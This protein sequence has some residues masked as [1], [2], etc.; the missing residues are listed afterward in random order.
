[1]E[2]VKSFALGQRGADDL[3]M[4]AANLAVQHGLLPSGVIKLWVRGAWSEVM[5]IHTEISPEAEEWDAPPKARRLAEKAFYALQ[6]GDYAKAEQL[7]KEALQLAPDDP[8]LL[9]NLGQA[10]KLQGRDEEHRRLM[11]QIREQHP[12]YFFGIVEAARECIA[13]NELDKATELLAPLWQKK[14][15]HVSEIAVLCSAQIELYLKQGNRDLARSCF[16]I[17]EQIY[18]DHPNVEVFRA[19]LEPKD[20]SWLLRKPFPRWR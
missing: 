6:D 11:Q 14:K 10:Y 3:R 7:L 9:N 15:M 18:P 4:R 16:N 12:D 5:L 20:F 1:L 8:R 17:L 13:R 2:A 19:R